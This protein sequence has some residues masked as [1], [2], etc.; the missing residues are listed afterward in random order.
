M[1]F[2]IEERFE[3]RAPVERVWR[4]MLDPREVVHCLPGAELVE[5]VDARTFH[6]NVKVKVGPVTM[7]YKGRVQMSEVD[8]AAHLV[9]LVGD[10]RE[11]TGSGSA[12]MTMESRLSALDAG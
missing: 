3:V 9:R 11:S 7:T 10:G 6:G 4:Y 2:R 12:K 8:E 5:V 1:G